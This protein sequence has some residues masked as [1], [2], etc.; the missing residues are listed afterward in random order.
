MAAFFING[1]AY[2][3]RTL[4]DTSTDPL[5]K[6]K[7]CRRDFAP[8]KELGLNTIRVDPFQNHDEGM[9]A[10]EETGMYLSLDLASSEHNIIRAS[11]QY[12]TKMWNNVRNTIDAFKGYSNTPGFFVGNE[13]TNDNKTTAASTY[14]KALLRDTKAYIHS[15][16]P[17]LSPVGYANNDDPEIRLQ[18][19]DYFNCSSDDER[20]DFFGIN[21]YEWGGDSTTYQ[22]SGYIDH[23]ADISS[24][25]VP[26][27]I[28]EYGRN[29]VSPR[30]F[31]EVV[32]IFGPDMTN[33][34]FGGIVYEWSQKDNNYGL[35][36]INVDNSVSLLSDFQALKT[37]ISSVRPTG[38]NMDA[39][40]EQRPH[41]V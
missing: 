14:V 2:Q 18:V 40:N 37:A 5:A 26:V 27:F 13:V 31:P 11:P 41:S 15:S 3:P 17:R 19:Q 8:M 16:A 39:Y 34:W 20:V 4:A 38:V 36:E 33:T 35:V 9:R 1:V 23:T 25:S 24:Y 10:L 6:P 32:S 7:D 28:S 29:L 22:T 12:D 30:T 21:L